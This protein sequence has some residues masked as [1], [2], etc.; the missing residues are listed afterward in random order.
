[1]ET[2]IWFVA[3]MTALFA[4]AILFPFGREPHPQ[5][6]EPSSQAKDG[7]NTTEPQGGSSHG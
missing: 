2:L 5:K 4:F 3:V 7:G 1:M 6:R